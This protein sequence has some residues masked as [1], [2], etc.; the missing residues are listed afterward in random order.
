MRRPNC[1]SHSWKCAHHQP[2]VAYFSPVK[3]PRQRISPSTSHLFFYSTEEANCKNL[4]SSIPSAWYDRWKLLAAPSCRR[5]IE[6]KLGQD[7]TFD[8]DGSQ[9]RLRAC[10]FLGTWRALLC[11]EVVR[12]G[13]AGDELHRF[14]RRFSGSLKQGQL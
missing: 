14:Q 8:P 6:T 7:R 1:V 11:G 12:T 10:P 9:G 5:V 3:P 2:P 13:A 4:W